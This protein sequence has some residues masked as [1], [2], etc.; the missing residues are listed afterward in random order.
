MK[1]SKPDSSSSSKGRF[2]VQRKS[3]AVMRVLRGELLD[4]VSREFG[5]SAATLSE[6]RDDF[7]AAGKDG[8]KSRGP[9]TADDREESLKA[10]IAH[11]AIDL[12]IL[13]RALKKVGADFPQ[14]TSM[15]SRKG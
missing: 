9:A 2:S 5:V 11:Q 15:N 12:E 4:V 13:K 6:W 7:I 10:I 3:D 14:G 8:L 1:L